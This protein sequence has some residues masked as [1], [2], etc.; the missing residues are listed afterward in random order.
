MADCAKHCRALSLSNNS[1]SNSSITPQQYISEPDP[2]VA[3]LTDRISEQESYTQVIEEW[4]D[5]KISILNDRI[6]EMKMEYQSLKLQLEYQKA[7]N[8]WIGNEDDAD[9]VVAVGFD[10]VALRGLQRLV[11][12]LEQENDELR[13][14]NESILA[15]NRT[16]RHKLAV[17]KESLSQM[18]PQIGELQEQ[19]TTD[20]SE[21]ES[22]MKDN[23][24]LRDQVNRLQEDNEQ[25][26]RQSRESVVFEVRYRTDDNL[27][28]PP[29]MDQGHYAV[30]SAASNFS[31][32][33]LYL[34][35][36]F[37][38]ASSTVG[39]DPFTNELPVHSE[40][41]SHSETVDF[42][43]DVINSMDLSPAKE[44]EER[45]NSGWNMAVQKRQKMKG[46]GPSKGHRRGISA[47][48]FRGIKRLWSKEE[49]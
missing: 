31:V 5:T 42:I 41:H 4:S 49:Q 6:E 3:E 34:T 23:D 13:S 17:Q 19:I 2:L 45:W 25:L 36:R 9:G 12:T 22:M 18:A 16:L 11:A 7:R 8:Q 35:N 26:R 29:P 43:E 1:L 21:V 27:L 14:E 28:A 10:V 20:Q 39:M 30:N 24:R 32:R 46:K 38:T 48:A 44:T 47:K 15:A 33:S 37:S 40:M